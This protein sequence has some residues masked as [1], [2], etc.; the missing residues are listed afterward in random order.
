MS[1]T[2]LALA[3]ALLAV[4]VAVGVLPGAAAAPTNP[5]AVQGLAAS[6]SPGPQATTS[7]G[8][9][10]VVVGVV[11]SGVNPYHDAYYDDPVSVTPEVLAELGVA[12]EHQVTLTRT[13]DLAADLA[14]DKAFWDSVRPGTP[15]WFTGTNLVGISFDDTGVPIFS[16][17]GDEHGTGTTSAVLDANPEAV[18]VLVEGINAHAEAWAFTH[19]AV[20]L[21]ST[22]YGLPGSVPFWHLTESYDG[23]VER[24]KMHFGA[25]D[26]SPALSPPDGTSGPWWSI[27]VAGFHEDTT[28]ARE[29][30]S[31]NVVDVVSDFTQKLPYCSDCETGRKD[32]SGTSFATPRSAGVAS[33]VLLEAR[34][35]AGHSGGIVVA[36]GAAPL[37]VD[38]SL[39][40][41][42]WQL[43]RALEEAAYYP[44]LDD[45]SGASGRNLPVAD[46]APYVQTGW[47]LLSPTEAYGVVDEALAQ[48][49]VRGE[50][51]ADKGGAACAWNTAQLELRR[52]Y[53]DSNPLFSDSF[54]TGEDP[55]IRC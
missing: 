44:G 26:N 49:G 9:A 19:P 18:V 36:D 34:R 4:P 39:Q 12:P 48:A 50:A 28:G 7:A 35:A 17:E 54:A 40:L 11:D 24:G 15:Y 43:R 42:G 14:A 25:S 30:M 21:V 3:G 10:R 55:Y 32:V 23:V 47:G 5:H 52:A 1:R 51:R 6:T 33:K 29:T 2:P 16:D 13:G 38:G 27:A 20:D 45:W 8:G 41:T 31:G 37:M 53:W 22:S 46:A